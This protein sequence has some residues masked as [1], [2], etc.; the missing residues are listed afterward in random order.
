[1]YIYLEDTKTL[2]NF[3]LKDVPEEV[4]NNVVL[5]TSELIKGAIL[6]GYTKTVSALYF[7]Y[8]NSFKTVGEESEVTFTPVEEIPHGAMVIKCHIENY[9]KLPEPN[10]DVVLGFSNE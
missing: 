4:L 8:R 1:M 2:R 3:Y 5:D 10:S 7:W 9:G 6:V